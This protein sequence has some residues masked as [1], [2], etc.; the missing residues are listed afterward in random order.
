MHEHGGEEIK[1]LERGLPYLLKHNRE[2]AEDLK[3]WI[4]RAKDGH[5]DDIADDLQRVHEL[6]SEITSQLES[7]LR[8]LEGSMK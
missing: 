4:Q 3:K 7:A 1:K 6:S 2:H 8:K 5:R